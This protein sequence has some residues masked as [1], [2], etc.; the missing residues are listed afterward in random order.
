[1]CALFILVM[2]C[3]SMKRR[4]HWGCGSQ[5]QQPAGRWLRKALLER[6]ALMLDMMDEW[7]FA[8]YLKVGRGLHAVVFFRKAPL[9]F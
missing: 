6:R 7:K 3:E 1:M 4:A 2:Q 5:K 9:L 8:R